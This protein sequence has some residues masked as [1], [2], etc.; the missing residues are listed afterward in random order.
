MCLL[1][2]FPQGWSI[3]D[4]FYTELRNRGDDWEDFE[5][6]IGGLA[7]FRAICSRRPFER[8]ILLRNTSVWENEVL[9]QAFQTGLSEQHVKHLYS[10]VTAESL[11]EDAEPVKVEFSTEC[12]E[13]FEI[14][15]LFEETI[16]PGLVL[17][18]IIVAGDRQL[19]DKTCESTSRFRLWVITYNKRGILFH[20]F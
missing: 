6:D 2:N 8:K 17:S 16:E 9:Q 18:E 19:E 7:L 14:G 1:R 20:P 11:L 13:P 4:T 15:L 12:E 3:Y 10:G 5:T